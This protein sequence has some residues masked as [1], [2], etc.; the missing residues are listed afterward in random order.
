M[1][2][3]VRGNYLLS[4]RT[5]EHEHVLAGLLLG[6]ILAQLALKDKRVRRIDDDEPLQHFRIGD[7]K[8]PG[9]RAAPVM[10][11]QRTRLCAQVLDK[12]AHIFDQVRHAIRFYILRLVGEI[13]AAHIRGHHCEIALKLLQLVFPGI[14]ELWK[15]VQE[16]HERP[17]T[18][19]YIMQTYAVEIG[20]AMIEHDLNTFL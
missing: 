5:L 8:D 1:R 2:I 15:T 10:G 18:R 17:L 3:I 14:P 12:P 20:I 6:R 16:K 9:C 19:D 13:V 7:G 4:L 11:D